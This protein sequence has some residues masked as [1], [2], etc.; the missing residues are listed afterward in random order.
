MR[1]LPVLPIVM[2]LA[3]ARVAPAQFGDESTKGPRPDKL[4]IEKWEIGVVVTAP[5]GP[6]SGIVSTVVLP[7]D[8][9]EQQVLIVSEDYSVT[10]ASH[11]ERMTGTVKQLVLSIPELPSGEEARAVLTFEIRRRTLLPPADTSIFVKANPK[12]LPKEIRTYLGP[13]PMIEINNGKI[14]ALAKEL[15]KASA[16]QNAWEQVAA[17]HQWIRENV[18][19]EKVKSQGA[20]HAL[21]SHS[22]DYYDLTS[23]FVAL[24]RDSDIPARSVWMHKYGYGEFYLE[25]DEGQGYWFPC[26]LTGD[27]AFGALA[28]QRPIWQKGDAFRVPERPRE[29]QR[30][31][32]PYLNAKGNEPVV[33]FPRQIIGAEAP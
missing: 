22:A 7:V 16:D 10:V 30:Y 2:V 5:S 18:K 19:H 13:S 27:A 20:A 15:I 28:D 1:T 6:C 14:K 11:T 12:K 25:D 32:D 8:W 29:I 9:P 3:T 21:K 4:Q 17:I 31:I 26:V 24:C 33:R 23:L